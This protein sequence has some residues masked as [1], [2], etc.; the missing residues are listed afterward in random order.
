MEEAVVA[1]KHERPNVIV[2]NYK[3]SKFIFDENQQSEH[4]FST[5]DWLEEVVLSFGSNVKGRIASFQNLTQTKQKSAVLLSELSMNIYFPVR[6]LNSQDNYW[7]FYN[8]IYA[9]HANGSDKTNI[10]FS[11]GLVYEVPVNYRVI[12]SQMKR[13]DLYT[14]CLCTNKIPSTMKFTY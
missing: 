6:G 12:A 13:C 1:S 8:L 2:S 5:L 7:L 11:N 14:K 9:Y 10:Y 3:T 4:K